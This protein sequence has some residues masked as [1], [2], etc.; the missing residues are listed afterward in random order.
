MI[1]SNISARGNNFQIPIHGL[2][3]NAEAINAL[4]QSEDAHDRLF[5]IGADGTREPAFDGAVIAIQN[6]F[7]NAKVTIKAAGATVPLILK[8]ATISAI[9]LSPLPSG[10][11]IEMSC[12]VLGEPSEDVSVNILALLEKNCTIAILNGRHEAKEAG[13]QEFPLE[14]VADPI[15]GV[16]VEGEG[17]EDEKPSRMARKIAVSEAKKKRGRKDVH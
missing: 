15:G 13:Q 12:T 2:L 16:E 3:L 17:E 10:S 14:G 7:K 9:K 1:G 8:P 5:R 11:E 6:K 4:M